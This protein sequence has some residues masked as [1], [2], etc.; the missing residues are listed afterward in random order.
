MCGLCGLIE[1]QIEW[2]DNL[3]ELPKR[4]ERYKR[5]K[6]INTITKPLKITVSDVQGVNYL[7]Q[8][9][10]GKTTIANGL[11]ELWAAITELSGKSIDV[12]DKE[13]LNQLQS[14]MSNT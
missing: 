2:G 1:A 7:V 4:Q 5:L 12:L 13:Y 9:M 10:T 8:T 3:G 11:H 14:V 6:L